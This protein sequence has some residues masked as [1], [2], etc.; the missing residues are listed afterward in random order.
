MKNCVVTGGNQ[1]IGL[2]IVRQLAQRAGTRTVLAARSE[3][4]G[5]AALAPLHSELAAAGVA[6]AAQRLEFQ[7]LDLTDQQSV[8]R[9]AGWAQQELKHVD[10]LVNNAGE[11]AV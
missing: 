2:E 10:V 6:D 9:F 4:R 11:W 5:R 3:E 1:G 7:Q 8:S